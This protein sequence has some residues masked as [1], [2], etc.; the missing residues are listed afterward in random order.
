MLE[1]ISHNLVNHK[2][3]LLN[4]DNFKHTLTLAISR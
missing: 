2:L 4:L 1:L 3:N